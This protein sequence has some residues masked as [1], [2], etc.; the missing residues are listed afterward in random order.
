[1]T[2][3]QA[4]ELIELIESFKIT[5]KIMIAALGFIG[6]VLLTKSYTVRIPK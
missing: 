2:E 3:L 6:G 5:F 4:A 1:M